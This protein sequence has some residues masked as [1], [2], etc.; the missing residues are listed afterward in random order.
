MG[1][2]WTGAQYSLYRLGLALV[3]LVALGWRCVSLARDAEAGLALAAGAATIGC[4]LVA[5]GLFDR[6]A[7]A[8]VAGLLV[9]LA[10]RGGLAGALP[11]A[12]ASVPLVL[13]LFVPRA[14]FGSWAARYRP[15]P[16]GGWRFPE[17]LYAIVWTT[18]ALLAAATVLSRMLDPAWATG[19]ALRIVLEGPAARPGLLRDALLACPAALLRWG[20]FS[21]LSIGLVFAALAPVRRL[22]PGCW[23]LMLFVHLG[24]VVFLRW[25]DLPVGLLALHLLAFDPA[26]IPPRRLP[27][28]PTLFYDGDCGVCHGFVRLILAEEPPGSALRFAPLGGATFLAAVPAGARERLPDSLVLA[29]GESGIRT[30]WAA[31]REVGG[32]LGGTW[33]LG[34]LAADLAPT[35]WLDRAYDAFAVVRRRIAGAPTRACP[36]IPP[37]LRRRFPEND[38]S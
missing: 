7:A 29:G 37:E 33:R 5:V 34:T 14:P 11:L 24:L 3:L 17:L 15:D 38:Y 13:H 36:I 1:N 2:G 12:T 23:F 18:L 4:I 32:W 25:P 19:E 22:R 30:R 26:W 9:L 21:L 16:G 6:A 27:G 31:V 20:S 8:L 35:A 10:I 28:Q